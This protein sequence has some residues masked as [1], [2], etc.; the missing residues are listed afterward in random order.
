[1]GA[2]YEVNQRDNTPLCALCAL[3]GLRRREHQD[4]EKNT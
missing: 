3:G 4:S 1:M 2:R